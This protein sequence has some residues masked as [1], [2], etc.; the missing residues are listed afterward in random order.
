VYIKA[1]YFSSFLFPALSIVGLGLGLLVELGTALVLFFYCIFSF[2][3]YIKRPKIS[4][5]LIDSVASR[6]GIGL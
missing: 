3:M 5:R 6:Y 2:P 4:H 1:P